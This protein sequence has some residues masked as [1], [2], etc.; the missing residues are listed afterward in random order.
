MA[1]TVNAAKAEKRKTYKRESQFVSSC[2][3]LFSNPT[4][5]IGLVIL[6]IIIF[7]AIAA[8]VLAPYSPYDT[9]FANINSK[10]SAI[11]FCGCDNLG[12]DIFS[13]LLY[14]ARYSLFLGIICSLVHT[15]IGVFLGSII[16]YIGGRFDMVTMRLVDIIAAIPGMLLTIVISTVLQP[17]FISTIIAMTVGGLPNGIRGSRALALKERS[18]EYLEAA[19]SVKCS[20]FR[21]IFKH[22]VPNIISPTIVGTTTGIGAMIMA[23]AS[24]AFIGFGVQPPTP[25]WGAMLSS[26]R[27]Y[28]LKYPHMCLFPGLCIA[29]TV[30][31]VNLFGDGL[32]DALDPKL[33]K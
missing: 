31:A 10:P 15:V 3:R 33:K 6:L 21:I 25:E 12:R 14:G 30:L 4:A 22:M 29:I 26:G 17:G 5:M 1:N 24:L 7:V 23:V 9:D 27:S 11:H 19:K 32:R 13:R 2:K 18:M 28:I 16:G 20:D 8:P